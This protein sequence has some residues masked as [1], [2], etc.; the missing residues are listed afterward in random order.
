M[1]YNCDPDPLFIP[2]IGWVLV[3]RRE[4]QVLVRG[5][6]AMDIPLPIANWVRERPFLCVSVNK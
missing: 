6:I 3:I 2:G 1:T 5:R 4:A